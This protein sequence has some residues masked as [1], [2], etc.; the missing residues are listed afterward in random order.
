MGWIPASMST[1]RLL[2]YDVCEALQPA[3]AALL[4]ENHAALH[5]PVP[6]VVAIP[7]DGEGGGGNGGA[8]PGQ[9]LAHLRSKPSIRCALAA[10]VA[11]LFFKGSHFLLRN[12]FR[13][14]LR[15]AL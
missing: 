11:L 8:N 6:L 5:Q 2:A 13:H 9:A 12:L 7:H 10:G 14:T 4:A 3:S 15:K 1:C